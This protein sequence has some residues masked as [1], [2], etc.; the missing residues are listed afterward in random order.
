M[1]T[2]RY[3]VKYIKFSKL[4][5]LYKNLR[6]VRFFSYYSLYV[7]IELR[8][9]SKLVRK[10][11]TK[12]KKNKFTQFLFVGFF[13]TLAPLHTNDFFILNVWKIFSH[14]KYIIY[15]LGNERKMKMKK[16]FWTAAKH[17]KWNDENFCVDKSAEI[18]ENERAT[19]I[20]VKML[21]IHSIY[22]DNSTF[23]TEKL[24][25]LC[26]VEWIAGW[27]HSQLN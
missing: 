16:C 7:H 4:R 11:K 8:F 24:F 9:I 21:A 12:K 22:Y 25:W 26:C 6:I 23:T 13:H 18:R 15:L 19:I 20:W 5:F 27:V 3:V 10:G 2:Y 1:Y 14:T 17:N